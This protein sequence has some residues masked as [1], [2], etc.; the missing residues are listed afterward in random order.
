MPFAFTNPWL[1]GGIAAIA[2]PI[3][4]HLFNRSRFQVVQWGAMH[5]LN[6][7]IRVNRKRVRIE[8][9]IL[10]MIRCAIPVILA[11]MMAQPI[12]TNWT[13]LSGDA[14]SGTVVLLDNSYSMEAG[15]GGSTHFNKAV[16][17][18]SQVIG[19]LKRGSEVSVIQMAGGVTPLTAEPTFDLKGMV[20]TLETQPSGF[21]AVDTLG[22]IE[23]GFASAASMGPSK[24]DIILISDFQKN[25]WV[26]DRDAAI[27]RVKELT[28]SMSVK[29]SLTLFKVGQEMRDNISVED[30]TFSRN[31]IGIK[32]PVT[33]RAT[34]TNRGRSDMNGLR[35]YFRVDGEELKAV[36]INVAKGEQQQVMFTHQ[37]ET[38]G[39]HVVEINTE[40]DALKAD[41][42]MRAAVPVWD[43]IPV[44]L[45]N[46]DPSD[47]PLQ[48]E[49]DFLEV[50]LQPFTA[51]QGK[52]ED[53]L[54]TEVVETKS[55]EPGQ[56]HDYR[57]VVLANV[58][59]LNDNQL[60]ALSQ[61]VRDGG[62]LLIFP[63]NQIDLGWY[64]SVLG[65]SNYD[66]LPMKYATISGD[67]DKPEQQTRI[68]QKH[69]DHPTLAGFNDRR[70]GDLSDGRISLWYRMKPHDAAA[71]SIAIM[72]TL[73]SGD[74]FLVES[75]VGEGRVIQAA[76]PCDTAWSNLPMRPYF[77]PMMQQLSTHL[78]ST[79]YPPRNVRVG[80]ELVA[81]VGQPDNTRA[82]G[83]IT[84]PDGVQHQVNIRERGS[85]GVVSFDD[86]RLP[87]MY[88]LKVGEDQPIHFVVNTMRSESELD[89]LSMD[90]VKE[91]AAAMG[92]G[93][94]SS[95][96]EYD[97]LDSTRR[98]GREMWRMILI[99]LLAFIFLEMFLE[100][101][102]VRRAA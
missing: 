15:T 4:I 44:L 23:A 100:Q 62:G 49:T 77:V 65:S 27:A 32:Q 33:I 41:N 25:N 81:F 50:A 58:P 59:R 39:S 85:R 70:N 67:L 57:V 8:Q 7:V 66:L 93:F 34:V 11:L 78:A 60:K 72:A 88:T 19:Q 73:A 3:A 94:V 10:L 64:N 30:I 48:G 14:K 12:M 71:S 35:V 6:T 63:G 52:L 9:L 1:L 26:A 92:A 74:P 75:L 83:I 84:S 51:S 37:F 46:G 29:P 42:V 91:I 76:I 40:A 36:E 43:R 68:V 90:E 5:L 21:G 97:E 47:E 79:V 101:W 86:T 98:F 89:Q 28:Q 53:L 20:K 24:R 2:I 55:L 99:G 56:L 80:E 95:W 96:D 45:V 69:F 22:S 87:G 61:F 13:A 31:V 82:S 16:E 54:K 17:N 102:F 38:A 18:T